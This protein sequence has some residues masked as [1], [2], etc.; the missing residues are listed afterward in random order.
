LILSALN[1]KQPNVISMAIP[2]NP[3][4]EKPPQPHTQWV[5]EVLD[6]V[7]IAKAEIDRG[8]GLDGETVVNGILDR[9]R[10]AKER[11]Y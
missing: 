6:R 10:Q 1:Y 8:E 4:T 2:L 5:A 9:F 11:Q 7:N 3:Q